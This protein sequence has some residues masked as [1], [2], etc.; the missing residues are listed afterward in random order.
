[1]SKTHSF[2]FLAGAT[3]MCVVF[4]P[5]PLLAQKKKPTEVPITTSSK[6]ALA[7]FQ[8]ARDK[9]DNV[10]FEAAVP[11]LDQAIQKDPDF[12]MAYAYRAV[13]GGGVALSRQNLDKALGLAEKVSPGEKHWILMTDAFFDGNAA[14]AK[15]EIDELLTLYPGDKRVHS[16]AGTYYGNMQSDLKA[17]LEQHTKAVAIDKTYAASYNQIGYLQSRLGQY[18]EA[19]QAF[20]Q[21]IA[22][23]PTSPN[24]YDSYA[25]LLLKTGRYDE[26]IAQYQKALEK[27]AGFVSANTGIGSNY[28]FKGDYAKARESYLRAF[29]QSPNVDGKTGALFW[30]TVS[31]VHEGKVDEALK[32]LED[33]RTFAEKENRIPYA[34]GTH[35]QAA[36]ILGETGQLARSVRHLEKAAESLENAS[37]PPS[38]RDGLKLNILEGRARVL[39]AVHEFEAARAVAE[40]YRALAATHQNP[41]EERS[42]QTLLAQ[43]ALEEGKGDE[44]LDHLQKAD[45]E[46]PY[47]WF[48]KAAAL[49]KK[50]DRVAASELYG[51]IVDWN[52]NSLAYAIVRP[53]AL[54][55]TLSKS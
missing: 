20:K 51:R 30:R 13:S 14:K 19:E 1:M 44:A 7:L 24:P 34:I 31:Y 52:Q 47:N 12:A 4:A 9:W 36:F 53:R 21:Y 35:L 40:K 37:L 6:E 39:L 16:L 25:E 50:G 54:K 27:D 45:P 5:A 55:K 49:E 41:F 26:S 43:I 42:L 17:A 33:A 11:L 8:Q 38:V 2:G 18:G 46:D 32:S 15:Q 10:E 22:L 3:L 28:V 23:R 29:E 48:Y